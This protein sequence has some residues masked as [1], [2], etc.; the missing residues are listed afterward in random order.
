MKKRFSLLFKEANLF[1]EQVLSVNQGKPRKK[2]KLA[3]L[4]STKFMQ[5]KK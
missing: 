2:L 3:K 5:G 1:M 4:D